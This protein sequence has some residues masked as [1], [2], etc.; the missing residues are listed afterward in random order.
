[1]FIDEARAT[2]RIAART[3]GPR[4]DQHLDAA[5]RGHAEKSETQEPAQLAHARIA[6]A[7]G[8]RG[9]A[10]RKPDLVAGRGAVDTLQHEFEVEAELQ[11]ADHDDGRLVRPQRD[12]LTAADFALHVESEAFEKAFH[13]G[14]ERR[15]PQAGYRS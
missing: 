7:A 11:L 6:L 5:G 3:P 2:F 12:Q 1:M 9:R 4:L 15:F 14:V 13:G 8:A 10:H